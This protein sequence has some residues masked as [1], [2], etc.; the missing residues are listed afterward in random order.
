MEGLRHLRC[1]TS[2]TFPQLEQMMIMEVFFL[3]F[4]APGFVV[5]CLEN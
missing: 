5:P 3:F 4:P 1:F 2:L